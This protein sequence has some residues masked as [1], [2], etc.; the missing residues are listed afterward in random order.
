MHLDFEVA[1]L[2]GFPECGGGV[3][4]F[5]DALE[6]VLAGDVYKTDALQ[7]YNGFSQLLRKLFQIQT[8]GNRYIISRNPKF[9][10]Q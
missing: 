9:I 10:P 3:L 4:A 5:K 7:T 2:I 8:P 6:Q 1:L